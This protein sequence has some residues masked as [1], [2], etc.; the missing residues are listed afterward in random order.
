MK[1]TA[2]YP[3]ATQRNHLQ[4][5]YNGQRRSE[6]LILTQRVHVRSAISI[7]GNRKH[8]FAVHALLLSSPCGSTSQLCSEFPCRWQRIVR[9]QKRASRGSGKLIGPKIDLPLSKVVMEAG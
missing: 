2:R 7:A 3:E 9:G 1:W 6:A 4:L 8:P 5:P